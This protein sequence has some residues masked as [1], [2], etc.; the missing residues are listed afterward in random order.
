MAHD[1]ILKM[2]AYLTRKGL[3][4]EKLKRE[5]AASLTKELRAASAAANQSKKLASL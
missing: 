4:S 2:E 5:N 1:P 3:F